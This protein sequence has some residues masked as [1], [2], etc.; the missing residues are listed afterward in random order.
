VREQSCVNRSKLKWLAVRT[1]DRAFL[2][3]PLAHCGYLEISGACD[4]SRNESLL[5]RHDNLAPQESS[6]V[7]CHLYVEK[8]PNLKEIE[9]AIRATWGGAVVRPRRTH[10]SPSPAV[11]ASECVE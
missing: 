8:W 9:M 11:A 2:S 7:D 6:E 1:R 5:K 4:S 10:A 3:R